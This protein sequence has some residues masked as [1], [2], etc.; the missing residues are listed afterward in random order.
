VKEVAG[1]DKECAVDHDIAVAVALCL[2]QL[3]Y[4]HQ[5]HQCYTGLLTENMAE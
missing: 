2:E 4:G 1:D 3:E 5:G